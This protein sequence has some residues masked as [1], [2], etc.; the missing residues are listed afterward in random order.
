MAALGPVEADAELLKDAVGVLAARP[1]ATLRR[2]SI[3]RRRKSRVAPDVGAIEET[4]AAVLPLK[5]CTAPIAYSLIRGHFPHLFEA[6]RP[7]RFRRCGE[8]IATVSN[9]LNSTVVPTASRTL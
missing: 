4:R 5:S 6:F 1:W 3:G 7:K 8:I 2:V 9:Q